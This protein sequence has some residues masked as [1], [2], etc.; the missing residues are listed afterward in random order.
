[1]LKNDCRKLAEELANV[2]DEVSDKAKALVNALI[3]IDSLK[4][5]L[6]KAQQASA[7]PGSS[8]RVSPRE[9]DVLELSKAN[10]ELAREL[11]AKK[12]TAAKTNRKL[13]DTKEE[14]TQVK[15]KLIET[16]SNL[17][18][19]LRELERKVRNG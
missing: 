6:K 18:L 3:R 9:T 8:E 4:E 5:D 1:M 10:M 16:E 17:D 2:T 12:E 7:S 15:R 14:L 19:A 11:R 13:A